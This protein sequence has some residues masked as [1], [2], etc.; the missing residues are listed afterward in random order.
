MYVVLRVVCLA[1]RVVYAALRVVCRA[2]L[3]VY[4]AL[5]AAYKCAEVNKYKLLRR[6]ILIYVIKI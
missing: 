5:R 6:D 3:V 1:L 2:L 4:V